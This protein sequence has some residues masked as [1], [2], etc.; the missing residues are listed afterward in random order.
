VVGFATG[1]ILALKGY[2]ASEAKQ[3]SDKLTF[4]F[5]AFPFAYATYFIGRYGATPGKKL[6]RLKVVTGDTDRVGYLRAFFRYISE[7]I[8]AL[9]LM[10]GYLM[11]IFDGKKRTLH[12]H[13]CDTRVI[14]N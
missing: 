12:D 14:K 11:A 13:I 3:I 10:T 7:H 6:C 1:A 8:S 4:I 2:Q 9:L 5:L